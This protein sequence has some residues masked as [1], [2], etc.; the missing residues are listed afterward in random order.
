MKLLVHGHPGSRLGFVVAFLQNKLLNNLFDVGGKKLSISYLKLHTFNQQ[1]VLL[2][3]GIKICIHTTLD[4]LDRHFI[5]FYQKN[6]QTQISTYQ[7]LLDT[8]RQIVDKMYYEFHSSWLP[9]S[10]ATL[11]ELYNY[12]INFEQTYDV[13]FMCDLYFKINKTVPS[14]RLI[15]AMQTTNQTNLQPMDK[16]HGCNV[17]AEIIKFEYLNNFSQHDR[18][19]NLNSTCSFTDEGTCL[20]PD[21][22]YDNVMSKLSPEF[23]QGP[24]GL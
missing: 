16:N 21:N 2:F 9:D 20:D 18:S 22:L 4:M 24:V 7:T 17:A 13:E 6:V 14:S 19:W 12:H 11:P 8:D 10:S 3:D 5:L 15:E 1:R 23:Y